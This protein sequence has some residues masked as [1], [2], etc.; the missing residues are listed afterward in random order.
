[1]NR[2]LALDELNELIVQDP[3]C[4]VGLLVRGRVQADRG[5]LVEAI[6]DATKAM[7]IGTQMSGR[8]RQ[9]T[10]KRVAEHACT[11]A[12]DQRNDLRE[13]IREDPIKAHIKYKAGPHGRINQIGVFILDPN[14]RVKL[15]NLL[16]NK[17]RNS[18]NVR[19]LM[20]ESVNRFQRLLAALCNDI[21]SVLGGCVFGRD[22]FLLASALPERYRS[23]LLGAQLLGHYLTDTK[24]P[25]ELE[26]GK[27]IAVASSQGY[28]V[29]TACDSDVLV[30]ITAERDPRR[31]PSLHRQIAAVLTSG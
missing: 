13:K 1:N 4:W 21:H 26:F 22:G 27:Q 8:N 11:L 9:R 25:Q 3:E 16:A 23:D 7:Q 31:L 15:E 30:I 12:A 28:V 2:L 18:A 19:R 29:L 20:P 24:D 10:L 6:I 17:T 5:N 14:D